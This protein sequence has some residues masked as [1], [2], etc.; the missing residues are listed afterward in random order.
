MTIA[1]LWHSLISRKSFAIV[2]Y[3]QFSV[4]LHI[5]GSVGV[6]CCILHRVPPG[7]PNTCIMTT[8]TVLLKKQT[9]VE[10][11]TDRSTM[12]YDNAKIQLNLKQITEL[13]KGIG[14]KLERKK[15]YKKS[16]Q[17]NKKGFRLWFCVTLQKSEGLSP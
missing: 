2:I 4:Y 10:K 11:I 3:E 12:D 14:S 6:L 8:S 7:Q 13:L 16:W 17:A 5:L 1:D 15:T 9:R